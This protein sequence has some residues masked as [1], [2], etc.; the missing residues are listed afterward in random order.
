M[1]VSSEQKEEENNQQAAAKTLQSILDDK[2]VYV[3]GNILTYWHT[4]YLPS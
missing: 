1:E 4:V 2:E 3:G